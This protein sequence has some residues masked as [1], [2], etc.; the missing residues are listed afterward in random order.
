MRKSKK[1]LARASVA[2]LLSS[3]MAMN[4]LASTVTTTGTVDVETTTGNN[5][6]IDVT[7]T[8]DKTTNSDGS[9]SVA[10]S[11]NATGYVTGSGAVVDYSSNSDGTTG[12]SKSEYTSKVETEENIY[13]AT[14]GTETSVGT[15]PN[16]PNAGTVDVPLTSEEGKNSNTVLGEGKVG[17][18]S[19][20]GDTD[21]TDGEYNYSTETVVG[22]GSVTVTTGNVT[23]TETVV[24]GSSNMEHIESETTPDGTNDI[25]QTGRDLADE[26]Y[27]P[28][29]DGDT[30]VPPNVTEGYEYVYAGTGNTSKYTPAIVFT[31]KLTDEEKLIWYGNNAYIGSSYT[32]YYVGR[33]P[34]EVK[35]TIQYDE[36]GNYVTDEF[37]FIL[38]KD[39]DR[40]F[41]EELTTKA[42]DG[43]TLYLHRFDATGAGHK[44]EGWYEDGEWV[45]DLNGSDKYTVVWAGPQQYVL[46]DSDGN[47]ITTYGADVRINTY[48]GFNYNIE[49]LEDADY[50]SAEEAEHIRTI[51]FNGYWGTEEGTGSLTAMKEMMRNALD[52]NGNRMFTD[53]EIDEYLNDGVALSATQMAIW[54]YSNKM[55]GFEVVNSHYADFGMGNV[56]EEK[57]DEVK[58]LF[59]LYDYL[60]NMEPT[61]TENTT[62]DTIINADN[63]L[64]DMSITVIEKAKD[65]ENNQDEDD[66]N[67]AYVTNIKFALVVEPS[68]EDD[69]LVVKVIAADGTILASGRV[70][71]Q[72]K[73]G[74][75]QLEKDAD[76]NYSFTNIT[77]T[78]GDQNFNITIEGIQNLDKGVYL[79]SSEVREETSS[80]TMVGM[81]E[82]E[83]SV[84]VS[85]NIEFNLNVEDEIIVTEK[86]WRDEETITKPSKNDQQQN[87][88]QQNNPPQEDQAQDDTAGSE[89]MDD[90][91]IRQEEPVF[92][93][94]IQ[95][96]EVPLASI[97][98]IEEEE[99]PLSDVVVLGATYIE[100]TMVPLA[101]LPETGDHSLLWMLMSFLSG[102]SLAGASLV[103]KMKKRKR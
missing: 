22:Q 18:S 80:K 6:T 7:I 64:S 88:Q 90:N 35:D 100:D 26:E 40:I 67:D 83:H 27:L 103:N 11:S 46:V 16:G 63:F 66:E 95:D 19:T 60:I 45:K 84:N 68:T 56:P 70:A 25:I 93:E 85:M 82:G 89:N 87:D 96:D 21:K 50:Y 94:E 9:V 20:T 79:Y 31:E 28:G 57:E 32:S 38:N 75:T 51:A 33:L 71:G 2:L 58:L 4:A 30:V 74:E 48:G 73:D 17:D 59:K 3:S 47:T 92:Y 15:N 37:G 76:G 23:V 102:L 78:E 62:A 43:E 98:M 53:T 99:V 81:A 13:T 39:G 101:V 77:L 5:E 97:V 86:V 14:G 52:E 69:D 91:E 36:L 24:P 10:T 42:P 8:I 61:K 1:T 12:N 72:A 41:K 54:S 55:A 65:H 49:N 34:K 29:Y 44:V